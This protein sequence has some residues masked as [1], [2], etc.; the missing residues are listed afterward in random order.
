M[1]KLISWG[2]V[3]HE[4]K[5]CTFC[6]MPKGSKGEHCMMA[7]DGCCKNEHK[8]FKTDKDQKPT[9][10]SFEFAKLF[11]ESIGVNFAYQ[12]NI[13][14]FSAAIEHPTA[15]APPLIAK[16]PAFLFNCNFRI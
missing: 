6:G 9:Q 3:N 4:S 15:N 14:L 12:S 16:V 10:A 11:S 5:N 2:L 1:G 7:K 13:I 8:V